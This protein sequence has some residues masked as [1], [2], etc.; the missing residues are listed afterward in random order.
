MGTPM[1]G[2][3]EELVVMGVLAVGL[4]AWG[5]FLVGWWWRAWRRK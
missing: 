3:V 1:V 5:A 2:D 4:L